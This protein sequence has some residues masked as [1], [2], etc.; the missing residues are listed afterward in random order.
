MDDS[1][2]TVVNLPPRAHG[3]AT[4]TAQ[5]RY[6]APPCCK[7]NSIQA[8]LLMHYSGRDS[9]QLEVTISVTL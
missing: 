1:K 2:L 3:E 4:I 8:E 5:L 9:A 7:L 6:P